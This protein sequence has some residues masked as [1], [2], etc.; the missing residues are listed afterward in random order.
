MSRTYREYVERNVFKENKGTSYTE[1]RDGYQSKKT[2]IRGKKMKTYGTKRWHFRY[3]PSREENTGLRN[4][5]AGH[6]ENINNVNRGRK[7]SIR[8]YLK[9]E[10]QKELDEVYCIENNFESSN[11]F[12]NL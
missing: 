2:T 9:K 10:L 12:Y 5:G 6:K 11:E 7:K 4:T 8:Q 3:Y 1:T